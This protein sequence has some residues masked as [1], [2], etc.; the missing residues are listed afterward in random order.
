MIDKILHRLAALT[1]IMAISLMLYFS[2]VL[3]YPFKILTFE[4]DKFPVL[5]P[6]VKAGDVVVFR[7]KWY[8]YSC[9]KGTV[10]RQL[11]N[12]YLYYYSPM[13]TLSNK[14]FNDKK[15]PL[16]IPSDVEPG[17]YFIR[18]IYTF[19]I[20]NFRIIEYVKDTESFKVVK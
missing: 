7:S 20:H 13:P 16:K 17:E 2:F 14:G 6:V 4:Y 12:N 1:L 5:T 18:N 9:A 8:R 3:F 19:K 10:S 15:I 11:V